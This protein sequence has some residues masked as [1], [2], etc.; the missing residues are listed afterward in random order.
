MAASPQTPALGSA[1]FAAVAAGA[2]AGGY[3]RIED[4]AARMAQLREERYLPDPARAAVYD[5]LF[6]EYR[7]LHD[8]FGRGGNDVMKRLRAIRA[9][10]LARTRSTTQRAGPTRA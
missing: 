7:L 3:D 6:A 8:H 4:A 9:R 10:A 2:A 5:E 1:M